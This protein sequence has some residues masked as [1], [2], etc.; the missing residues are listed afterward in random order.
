MPLNLPASSIGPLPSWLWDEFQD[1]TPHPAPWFLSSYSLIGPHCGWGKTDEQ[2]IQHLPPGRL[3]ETSREANSPE[4]SQGGRREDGCLAAHQHPVAEA[5][6]RQG[7][8]WGQLRV[9]VCVSGQ[10][11]SPEAVP[12]PAGTSYHCPPTT[13]LQLDSSLSGSMGVLE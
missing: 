6:E 10:D 9:G 2:I 1:S 13:V 7:G 12:L 8:Q 3:G 11:A 4:E 5:L